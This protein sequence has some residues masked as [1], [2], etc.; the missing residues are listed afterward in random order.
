MSVLIIPF[1]SCLV[2]HVSD[3]M[4]FIMSIK[5]CFERSRVEYNN[6]LLGSDKVGTVLCFKN[7]GMVRVL[8]L[9]HSIQVISN[10]TSFHCF[11][12]NFLLERAYGMGLKKVFLL[13]AKNS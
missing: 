11:V 6:N 3:Y 9:V 8:P 1:K 2:V 10:D 7:I 4:P 13:T 5:H 12:L